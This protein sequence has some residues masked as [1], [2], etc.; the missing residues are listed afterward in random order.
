MSDIFSTTALTC[1]VQ[2]PAT[3][4]WVFRPAFR[5]FMWLRLAIWVMRSACD[6]SL[7]H[8]RSFCLAGMLGL[9]FVFFLTVSGV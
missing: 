3:E 1:F 8:G 6:L 9:F 2:P 7:L 5:R 4:H